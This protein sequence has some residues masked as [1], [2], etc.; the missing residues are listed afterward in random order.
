[1]HWILFFL[2]VIAFAPMRLIINVWH[3]TLTDVQVRIF[4]WGVGINLRFR[5]LRAEAGRQ[6]LFIDRHDHARPIRARPGQVRQGVS[7]LRAFF[8]S[9]TA[10][11][12][13]L[14]HI[15]LQSLQIAFRLGLAN[16][17]RTAVLTGAIQVLQ[18]MVPER[19]RKR[20]CVYA[21]PDFVREE[22]LTQARCIVFFH[23]G[24]LLITAAMALA[25]Y[26]LERRART[27]QTVKEA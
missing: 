1:M 5:M 27:P 14:R 2:L 25:A 8:R 6:V 12:L 21:R 26:W 16:A 11:R 4:L 20:I 22:T 19:M 15:D 17:A 3:S 7:L 9:D 23:L 10:R 18:Q 13:L 24:T